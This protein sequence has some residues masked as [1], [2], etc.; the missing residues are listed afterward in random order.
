MWILSIAWICHYRKTGS[1]GPRSTRLQNRLAAAVSG[2]SRLPTSYI[3]TGNSKQYP[4]W[5]HNKAPGRPRGQVCKRP[6][7]HPVQQL[8]PSQPSSFISPPSNRFRHHHVRRSQ[9]GELAGGGEAHSLLTTPSARGTRHKPQG[10]GGASRA[11]RR[12]GKAPRQASCSPAQEGCGGRTARRP[13]CR[14]DRRAGE[15]AEAPCSEA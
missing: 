2:S 8:S 11:W 1:T 9:R 7:S 14:D 10:S 13:T 4:G 12:I 15:S 3:R 6:S 5:L